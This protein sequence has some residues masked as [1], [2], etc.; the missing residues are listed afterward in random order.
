VVWSFLAGLG[1]ILLSARADSITLQNGYTPT[2]TILQTNR[3]RNTI[4]LLRDYGTA[5]YYIPTI[6][7]IK[8][9]TEEVVPVPAVPQE[10]GR[11][12]HWQHMV[13][14]LSKQPWAQNLR[15]IPATVIDKGILRNVPYVSFQCGEDYE[16][17]IYGDLDKPAGFE[18]GIYRKP[19]SDNAA[20]EN[21]VRLVD[22]LLSEPADKEI[23]G[24][25]KREKDSA[26]RSG[27]T[28]EVTPPT[29][30]DAYL[31]WWISIYDE[32]RLNLARASESEMKQVS[33]AKTQTTAEV[34]TA[35]ANPG[36]T[37]EEMRLARP[38]QPYQARFVPVSA[39]GGYTP[40]RT[41]TPAPTYNSD[42]YSPSSSH[43]GGGQVYVRGYTRKD[44]T[45]V[46]AHTRSAPRH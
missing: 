43:S 1:L 5:T 34:A 35:P 4:L 26:T 41:A 22:A 23:L 24:K 37:A 8:L 18:I 31:G 42:G 27:L 38:A 45:Y 25:L 9:D 29:A 17:N 13:L 21:C 7:A 40:P 2:G 15:Q 6:K 46:P 36:W 3:E 33:V 14:A 12:P 19:L 16:V 32:K 30:E 39:G 11:W 20:K 28:F 10:A 44:G